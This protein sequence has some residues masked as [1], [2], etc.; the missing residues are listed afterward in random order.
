[1]NKLEIVKNLNNSPKIFQ[2]VTSLQEQIESMQSELENFP[3]NLSEELKEIILPLQNL[4]EEVKKIL[5]VYNKINE[6]QRNTLNELLQSMIEQSSEMYNQKTEELQLTVKNLKTNIEK[7]SKTLSHLE[8]QNQMYLV[9]KKSIETN[10][11]SL[12]NTSQQTIKEIFRIKEEQHNKFWK[13]IGIIIGTT[14]LA[15][16][17]TMVCSQIVRQQFLTD[18]IIKQSQQLD[19]IVKKATKKEMLL[20]NQIYARPEN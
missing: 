15:T 9:T 10:I 18:Q 2:N 4:K 12:N 5:E 13:M 16:L 20:I 7:F 8:D 19:S 3:E 17:L 11:E 1:M 14:I 6:N